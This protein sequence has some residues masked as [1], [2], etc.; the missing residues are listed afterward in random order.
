MGVAKRGG[1]DRAQA[2]CGCGVLTLRPGARDPILIRMR[3]LILTAALLVTAC[4]HLNV[5]DAGNGRH[6]VTGSAASGGYTGSREEAIEQANAYCDESHQ[7][8]VIDSFDDKPGVGPRGEHTSGMLFTC[9]PPLVL[10]F[11]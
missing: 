5:Q 8:A 7:R 2:L 9:A 1:H 4:T 3:I 11:Q 10:R 6:L